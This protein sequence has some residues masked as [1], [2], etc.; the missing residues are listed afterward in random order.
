MYQKSNNPILVIAIILALFNPLIVLVFLVLY[1]RIKSSK[2][3]KNITVISLIAICLVFPYYI[4]N[5]FSVIFMSLQPFLYNDLEAYSSV[6]DWYFTLLKGYGLVG[7]FALFHIGYA[8]VLMIKEA[9]RPNILI[10]TL[11]ETVNQLA[12]NE[13]DFSL[14]YAEGDDKTLLGYN[15]NTPVFI[16][17]NTTHVFIAG[18]T[19][20]GKT[21]ALANFIESA[22]SKDYPLLLVDGKGDTGKDSML[23]IVNQL[24]GDRKLIVI[25]MNNPRE[26]V[27]YNPFRNAT[28]SVLKDMLIDMSEWSEEHYKASTERYI[29]RI[30]NLM[31]KVG[32]VYSF[33]NVIKY[34]PK[35][36][37]IALADTCLKEGILSKEEYSDTIDIIEDCGEIANSAAA[38]FL[39][40]AESDV[41]NIFHEDGINIYDALATGAIVLFILNPLLYPVLS[42]SFGKLVMIDSKV[43]VSHLYKQRLGRCFFIYDEFGTYASNSL[44][45]MINKSRSAGV[46]C[47]LATQSLSDLDDAVGREYREQVIENC[48]NYIIMRQNSAENAGAWAE[49]IGT[50]EV[51][52]S[53]YSYQSGENSAISVGI[54]STR[55]VHEFIYHPN[56]IKNMGLGDAI[57]VSKDAKTKG[58]TTFKVRKGF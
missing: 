1:R 24:R 16:Y 14:I 41:G 27:K 32:I 54:G 9:R 12:V 40:I 6:F 28:P 8:S 30:A 34:L 46:T 55:K 58:H 38:R 18:T 15:G 37:A 20:S 49:I 43:C 23:D 4:V 42:K 47:I 53:T 56:Y 17:D 52:D 51:L 13:E 35:R 57:F 36:G 29:Q 21:V 48:N 22:I 50:K 3:A 39:T 5:L 26:S 10:P 31:E 2:R 33:G 7:H 25:D 44:I 45:N 19:G 11:E